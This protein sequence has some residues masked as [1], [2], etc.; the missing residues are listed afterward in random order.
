[1]GRTSPEGFGN[2]AARVRPNMAFAQAKARATTAHHDRQIRRN[3]G[4]GFMKPLIR[5]NF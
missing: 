4:F 5:L 1:M 2:S 3:E